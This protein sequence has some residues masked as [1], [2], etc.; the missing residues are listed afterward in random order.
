MLAVQWLAQRQAG[1]G[2]IGGLGQ[3]SIGIKVD[4]QAQSEAS[5]ST[6]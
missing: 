4:Q 5:S 6:R 3:R 2:K 1:H